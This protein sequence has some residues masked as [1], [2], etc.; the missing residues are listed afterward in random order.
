[1]G[2]SVRE[3]AAK[4]GV[5]KSSIYRWEGGKTANIGIRKG[6]EK[7]AIFFGA[8][9]EDLLRDD[10]T[11]AGPLVPLDAETRPDG[12]VVGRTLDAW[13]SPALAYDEGGAPVR[14][15][16]AGAGERWFAARLGPVTP[17]LVP[18]D[19]G[20]NGAPRAW[21]LHEGAVVVFRPIGKDERPHDALVIVEMDEPD[22]EAEP[23]RELR[24]VERGRGRAL[25]LHPVAPGAEAVAMK[26]DWDIIA[27][28]VEA[29]YGL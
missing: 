26:R 1:M 4:T 29:R 19:P 5:P 28:G 18:R 9:V 7:L 27:V 16:V 21:H 15:P 12:Q 13:Q 10:A 25:L 22:G 3:L 24:I 23:R 17:E 6:L 20:P 8:T 11:D 14:I 2:L